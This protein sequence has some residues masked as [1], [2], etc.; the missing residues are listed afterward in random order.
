VNRRRCVCVCVLTEIF[1]AA[2]DAIKEAT[3]ATSV[4]MGKKVELPEQQPYVSDSHPRTQ[5]CAW[6][7]GLTGEYAN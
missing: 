3:G 4:Y 6:L 5:P 1:G 7:E 2:L